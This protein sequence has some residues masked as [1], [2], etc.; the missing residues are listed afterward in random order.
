MS[1][2]VRS[3]GAIACWGSNIDGLLGDGTSTRRTTPVAVTGIS[4]A[5]Q[6]SLGGYHGCARRRTGA[7]M[8]WGM[9]TVGELGDGT[10]TASLTPVT[11]LGLTDATSVSVA[12]NPDIDHV[13]ALQATGALS[14]WGVRG[15]G[16]PVLAPTR[17]WGP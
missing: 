5:T 15:L 1:C 11:A 2:A 6:V 13:C 3:T 16:L 4:D 8:C 7:V 12:G 17:V 9:N 10:T 14:C